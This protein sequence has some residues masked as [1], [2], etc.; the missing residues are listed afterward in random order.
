LPKKF[1]YLSTVGTL[2]ARRGLAG[3]VAHGSSLPRR[4]VSAGRPGAFDEPLGIGPL[5]T[6]RSRGGTRATEACLASRR[7]PPF[8]LRSAQK[9]RASARPAL[10][11]SYYLETDP[12]TLIPV[13]AS[14]VLT[15]PILVVVNI[16]P[17]PG[18]GDIG[19]AG[20]RYGSRSARNVCS[21]SQ[22][23]QTNISLC[24]PKLRAAASISLS[25]SSP[26]QRQPKMTPFAPCLWT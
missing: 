24:F 25:R 6:L 16:S 15:P 19:R 20:D 7:G 3:P 8:P 9:K 5:V 13:A 23:V 11:A 22:L 18:R 21:R 17:L 26:P 14:L 2:S 12:N 4:R 1:R 10:P